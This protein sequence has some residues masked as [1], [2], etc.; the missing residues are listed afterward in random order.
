MTLVDISQPDFKSM[1]LGPKMMALGDRERRFVWFYCM[2][3]GNATQ[4]AKDAGYSNVAEGARVRAFEL[5]HRQKILDAIGEAGRQMFK[6]LLVPAIAAMRAMIDR[7]DHPDHAKM[8]NSALDRLGLA[9]SSNVNVNMNVSG[10]VTVNHTD[11]ALEDLRRL[12][13]LRVPRETLVEMFG[14]SGLVRY[15]RMLAEKGGG[16]KLIEGASHE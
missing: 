5:M 13:L 6:G 8:V 7:P 15:E 2:N 9:G 12:L 3:N 14:D 1:T 4:A 11:A 16:P 10:E